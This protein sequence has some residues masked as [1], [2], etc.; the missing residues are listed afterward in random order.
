[1]FKLKQ[2]KDVWYDLGQG[3]YQRLDQDQNRDKGLSYKLR[4]LIYFLK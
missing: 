4:L 1:M 2:D 3:D